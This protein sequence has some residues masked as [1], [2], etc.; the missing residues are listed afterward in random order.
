MIYRRA[1]KDAETN[2]PFAVDLPSLKLWQ[3]EDAGKGRKAKDNSA[4]ALSASL[5]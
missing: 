4:S 1:A 3:G 2:F 5:R